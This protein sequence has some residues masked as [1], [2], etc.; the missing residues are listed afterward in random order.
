MFYGTHDRANRA[1][2][3]LKVAAEYTSLSKD[4]TELI[5]WLVL[6]SHR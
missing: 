5:P 4:T 1:D 2:R 6:S 3:Y